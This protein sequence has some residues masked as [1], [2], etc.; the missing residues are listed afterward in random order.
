MMGSIRSK[1][2]FV[3]E[4]ILITA[5]VIVGVIVS[6]V[7]KEALIG[8]ITKDLDGYVQ[9]FKI[10]LENNPDMDF[11]VIAQLCN[12]E[13]IIG[14]KGFIF[15]TDSKGNLLIHKKAAGEN[16]ANKPH[17]K[18][19]ITKKQGNLRFLSPKTN[20]YKIASF[21][22]LE[23]FDWIIVASAFEEDFLAKPQALMVRNLFLIGF[24]ISTVGAFIIF[25]FT[26]LLIKPLFMVTNAATGLASRAGDLTQKIKVASRDEIGKL[27][28]A[29]NSIVDSMHSMVFQIRDSAGKVATSSQQLSSSS[30]EMN[31]STQEVS[32]AIQEISKGATTQAK[33]AE[34]AVDIMEKASVSLTQIMENAQTATVG[35]T[36]ASEQAEIGRITAQDTMGKIAA[37]TET[38]NSTAEVIQGLGESSQQIG[39][40]T[41]TI[42]SIADQTN[43][44][45]LNAAIEAARAGEAGRGFAVVAEE[46][47][48]LAEA[49][50]EAVRKIGNLIK[51]TQSETSRAVSSIVT[52]SK[53]VEE[54]KTL[55][56]NIADLLIEINTAIKEATVIT[57][58]ISEATAEQAKGT[59][60][61]VEVA[62]E[63]SSIA[64]DAV[65]NTQQVSSSVEEQTSSMQ[66]MSASAQEL[67]RM[68]M[69]LKDMVSKFKLRETNK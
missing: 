64:K 48:K 41:E 30:Q 25:F 6:N 56:G 24:A 28:E 17:I 49:S 67:A 1:M 57:K 68:G 22:Y 33:R 42:T 31:A 55:V 36:K 46:V 4:A 14:E 5:L 26:S 52:S 38:V 8:T 12:E 39:E 40:I 15:I 58:Q 13:I 65:S 21:E 3:F 61:V 50:A 10:L 44:L 47:R 66:E 63:V 16:W 19:I 2:L 59:G 37:L 62:K 20:T 35:I 27:A 43:L 11:D 23:D 29:F 9:Q 60:Q 53:E 7:S 32:T 69:E 45:A 51:S 34:E 54:G 18:E